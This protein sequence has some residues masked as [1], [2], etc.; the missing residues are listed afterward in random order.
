MK[1]ALRILAFSTVI[2]SGCEKEKDEPLLVLS[3][4]YYS[5]NTILAANPIMMYTNK[6]VVKDQQVINRF[7]LHRPWSKNSFSQTDTAIPNNSSC[8]FV[9]FPI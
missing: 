9:G 3:G 2:L 6:G 4:E 1:Q 8:Q 7:L 5:E